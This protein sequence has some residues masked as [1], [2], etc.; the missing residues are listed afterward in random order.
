M[1]RR[2]DSRGFDAS[3]WT[4]TTAAGALRAHGCR[5]T[6]PRVA[7]LQALLEHGAPID[8]T[9]LTVLAQRYEPTIHEA[10]VYRTVN[11]LAEV[12]ITTHVHA[13][14]GP[15][16]VGLRGGSDV[17][18]VCR[19][20]GAIEAVPTAAVDDLADRVRRSTGYVIELGHFALEGVCPDCSR[21]EAPS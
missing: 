2:E 20:C 7:V 17:V 10:T 9:A 13:G 1:M 6:R 12:G 8:A 19:D 4:V 15:S 3:A 5:V 11:V 16:L 14:H 21:D 18:A